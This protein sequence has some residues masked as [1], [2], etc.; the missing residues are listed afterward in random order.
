MVTP[1]GSNPSIVFQSLLD[2]KSGISSNQLFEGFGVPSV[3]GHVL[4]DYDTLDY[5]T[6]KEIRTHD[7]YLEYAI[8]ASYNALNMANL[9]NDRST[10]CNE[11]IGVSISTCVAGTDT[12]TSVQ[13]KV[14][15]KGLKYI[16]PYYIPFSLASMCASVVS[17]KFSFHGPSVSIATACAS[18]NTSI[19]DGVNKIKNNQAKVMIVGERNHV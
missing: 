13:E 8:V 2:G 11:D 15:K 3:G 16:S 9:L 10:Y 7:K 12:Q 6:R 17:K 18:S 4:C 19:I 5:L 14:S 1:L